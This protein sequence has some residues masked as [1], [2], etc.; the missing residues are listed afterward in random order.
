MSRRK[1]ILVKCGIFSL[2]LFS[3]LIA[4]VAGEIGFRLYQRWDAGIPFR[5]SL[6]QDEWN[7]AWPLILDDALGWRAR[8]GYQ[9][10]HEVTET[11][12]KG[13]RYPV[14]RSQKEYG[15]RMFGD[16]RSTR[17]KVLVIG[18]SFTH[19]TQVS[20][21]DTYYA[22]LKNTLGVEVF[23]YGASGYGTLQ[24]YM[25]LDQYVDMI[26]PTLIL[27]QFCTNDFINNDPALET[28][29]LV[30]NNG[31]RRPYWVDGH[32]IYL[33]PK[34]WSAS[35]RIFAQRHSRFA[36]FL[37]S[38]WDRLLAMHPEETVEVEIEREGLVHQGFQHA[39]QVTSELMG[40]VRSRV[41]RIPII[42]F[43]CVDGE[44]YDSAFK[45]ISSHY[46]VVFLQDIAEAVGAAHKRGD[47][48]LHAD[49]GHWSVEGHRLAGS[50]ISEHL[51]AMI[52]SVSQI[53]SRDTKEMARP[54]P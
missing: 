38:R 34:G 22:S 28:A 44:P 16:L 37:L 41:G 19:A 10:F 49:M 52:P 18:D 5:S 46:D 30:N 51:R 14:K 40:K 21:N 50:L 12:S 26:K 24:E 47:D 23:A 53:Q 25:I 31:W 11:T 45:V 35:F 1:S 7:P 13:V 3:V 15:F 54:N 42:A 33:L 8:A 9:D 27:W 39:V 17:P 2:P 48:V 4:F 32:I 29:S 36:H 20:D 6:G 43:S